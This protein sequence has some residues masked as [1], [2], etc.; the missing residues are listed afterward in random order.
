MGVVKKKEEKTMERLK[1]AMVFMV[2]LVMI[3]LIIPLSVS[4]AEIE[5]QN[6]PHDH[7]EEVVEETSEIGITPRYTVSCPKGGKHHM[8]GRGWGYCYSGS[9]LNPGKLL[10]KGATSQCV[11]CYIVLVSDGNVFHGQKIGK[12]VLWNANGNVSN[13]ATF[14]Y[15]GIL[16]TFN[17]NRTSD[18]FLSGFEWGNWL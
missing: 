5:T 4:A 16:G 7:A 14:V 3:S 9:L 11:K 18:P 8:A 10:I 17:G 6:A 15:G 2:S 13:A 12:Y 1:K